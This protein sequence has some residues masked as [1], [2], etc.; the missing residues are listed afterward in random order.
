MH[1]ELQMATADLASYLQER[2]SDL[3]ENWW[4]DYIYSR[5]SF[6]QQRIVGERN[7][8]SLKQ[9]DIAALLRIFDQNWQELSKDG[10]LP[11]ETR[12]WIKELQSVRNKWAHL[13]SEEMPPSE[14]YRDADTLNLIL[15]IIGAR[16]S[17]INAVSLAKNIALNEMTNRRGNNDHQVNH[18]QN[19]GGSSERVN[20]YKI[21]EIVSLRSNDNV[22]FPITDVDN[23][24]PETRYIVFQDGAAATYYES[25]L[26]AIPEEADEH[27]PISVSELRA[28][29][30]ALHLLSPSTAKLFSWRS[31]RINFIPYQYRPVF[32]IIRSDQPRLLIAD[33]VG[34][35]KTIE[36]GLILKELRARMDLSSVLII[37]PKPLITA[38]KWQTEMKRF[39]ESFIHIDSPTFRECITDANLNGIWP[40]AYEKAILPFSLFRSDVMY[41]PEGSRRH[42]DKG[43]MSLSPPPSFD[44]V[45]VDE[46]HH[47]RNQETHLH[48]G[49]RYFCDNAKAVIL[50]S[51]TPIQLGNDDLFTLLKVIRPDLI[52]DRASFD[53]MAEPNPYINEAVRLCRENHNDWPRKA[54]TQL[55]R[56]VQTRWGR[57]FMR[58]DPLF[59]S[60]YDICQRDEITD[61]DR[62]TL[63]KN[64]EQLYTFSSIIN[65][66][67]RRDIGEF[68][69]RRPET[70]TVPYTKDQRSLHDDLLSVI[71]QILEQSHGQQNVKFLMSVLRR[72]AASCLYG[73]APLISDIIGR[74]LS[75]LELVEIDDA[76]EELDL[77]VMANIHSYVKDIIMRAR[78]LDPVDP[79]VREFI[80]ILKEKSI[81]EKNKTLVFSTFRHT[82]AYLAQHAES[83]GL[84]YGLIHGSI[85]DSERMELQKRFSRPKNDKDAIDVL[86]SSEVGCEGLD[87]QFCDFLVN[88]DLPWNPMKIEQRIGR[89]DRFGQSSEAIRIVNLVTPKTVDAEI[90]NRC[91]Q[92]IGVFNSA[93][94]GSEEILGKVTNEI[95]SIA[96]NYT[97]T[98]NERNAQLQQIADNTIRRANEERELERKEAELFGLDVPSAVI[99]DDDRGIESE[100][101][102]PSSIKICVDTYLGNLIDPVV[103]YLLDDKSIAVLKLTTSSKRI[104]L[105]DFR[106]VK[107]QSDQASQKWEEWLT[108]GELSVQVTFDQEAASTNSEVI[109]L[110]ALHPLVRQAAL[111]LEVNGFICCNLRIDS[112]SVKNLPE[113]KFRFSLY[114]WQKTG[115]KVDEELIVISEKPDIDGVL[116]SALANAVDTG[117]TRAMHP[118]EFRDIEELHHKKWISARANHVQQNRELAEHRIQSLSA[119][120]GARVT[121]LKSQIDNATDNRI[122]GMRQSQ[123]DSANADFDR[124]T[125]KLTLDGDSGDIR[126]TLVLL[127]RIEVYREDKGSD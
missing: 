60:A 46:A 70:V 119:S 11:R 55:D 97:L 66:T 85:P 57:M 2:L 96:D 106:K 125:E 104:L 13:G 81:R 5:L 90:Y 99:R 17:T 88:Y 71:G 61:E 30:I 4:D 29:L 56:A 98:E 22:K 116:L 82:L 21:G 36:A 18:E 44:L 83:E 40:R 39:D 103:D 45:I 1:T 35:G 47:I 10:A 89:I 127:G 75:R 84:R 62:V 113:G 87:F 6:Q 105:E 43:L 69:I 107:R 109:Y 27:C 78:N 114:R 77:D 95:Q 74:N 23:D 110:N 65:R 112:E 31:G 123:L 92:R 8:T 124:R 9:L 53:Q 80:R 121:L 93:I 111:H 14:V 102:S 41:G 34:V 100:W 117:S 24:G 12:N 59:Q 115:I 42:V 126:A 51:A 86:L 7:I 67:R 49:V 58:E 33:E 118:N 32:K 3:S 68:T 37:C 19:A 101:I 48:R 63:T 50:M 15:E 72:Q 76:S 54:T 94:G 16:K 20:L 79:K 122:Q 91:L 28:R 120:H 25:Q 52:F 38:R 64:L 108:S 26:Q 73:L